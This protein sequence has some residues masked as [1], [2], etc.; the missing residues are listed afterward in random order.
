MT[1]SPVRVIAPSS[2]PARG[3]EEAEAAEANNNIGDSGRQARPR[4]EGRRGQPKSSYW[5]ES[6]GMTK[7]LRHVQMR[8]AQLLAEAAEL[9]REKANIELELVKE[10]RT[11][12]E[13][14]FKSDMRRKKYEEGRAHMLYQ[15]CNKEY[16]AKFGKHYNMDEVMNSL[17][18]LLSLVFCSVADPF[19]FDT[20]PGI[21]S[22]KNGSVSDLN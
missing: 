16:L 10:Q 18:F 5:E 12:D 9:K 2:T 22:W 20:N 3:G 11:R 15:L 14:I 17:H 8:E 19:N 21:V 4:Q 1:V 7:D 13:E 6:L